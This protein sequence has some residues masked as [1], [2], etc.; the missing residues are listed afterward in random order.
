MNR[1]SG[2]IY[3]LDVDGRVSQLTPRESGITNAV[4]WTDDARF[5]TADT[6][7]NAIYAHDLRAGVL[8]NKRVFAP[9]LDRGGP[10][11]LCL[12][13]KGRLWNRRVAGGACVACIGSDGALDRFVDLPCTWPTS[14][15]FGGPDFGTSM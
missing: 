9:P 13:V 6:T 8:S 15:A 10:T 7:R 5:L 3:R 12:D 11:G 1:D 4:A 14:C 2:A